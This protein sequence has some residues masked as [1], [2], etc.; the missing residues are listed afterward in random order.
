[1]LGEHL[2]A[3]ADAE[4]RPLL[5]QRHFDPV[6]LARDIVVTVVGAHRTAED[7]GAGMGVERFGKG[8]AEARPADV[9]GMAERSQGI[10]DPARCRVLLMQH[11]QHR[12]QRRS[13]LPGKG[14]T[15]LICAIRRP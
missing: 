6:D 12:T 9:E 10:A 14:T 8:I 1:M 3:Q 13:A 5:P 2:R 15:S 11:D 4:E 7:H